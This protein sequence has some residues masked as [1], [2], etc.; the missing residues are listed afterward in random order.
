LIHNKGKVNCSNHQKSSSKAQIAAYSLMI[1]AVADRGGL[2]PQV[3]RKARITREIAAIF[4]ITLGFQSA[5]VKPRE[6]L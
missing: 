6:G 4:F 1:L 3:S 5:R 2:K